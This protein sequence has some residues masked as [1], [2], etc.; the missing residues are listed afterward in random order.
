[1]REYVC[2]RAADVWAAWDRIGWVKDTVHA[3]QRN[4]WSTAGS[5]LPL[6]RERIAR[7]SADDISASHTIEKS[8]DSKFAITED[9]LKGSMLPET[10]RLNKLDISAK[11][12]ETWVCLL[13]CAP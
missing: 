8:A 11:R 5:E 3:I 13:P 2:M 6:G 4:A 1:M 12:P 9:H 10:V 7:L